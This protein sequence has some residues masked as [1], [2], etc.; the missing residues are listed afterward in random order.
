MNQALQDGYANASF[1]GFKS[2]HVF[3]QVQKEFEAD[4]AP[5]GILPWQRKVLPKANEIN[6]LGSHILHWIGLKELVGFRLPKF[7]K[8]TRVGFLWQD[9]L[10]KT[11]FARPPNYQPVAGGEPGVNKTKSES[12]SDNW[13]TPQHA[14][15]CLFCGCKGSCHSRR[16]GCSQ[17]FN[18]RS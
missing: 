10:C 13:P 16:C 8:L 6:A 18:A 15:T 2:Q 14:T 1:S 7:E 4:G 17:V 12:K 5:L 9:G 11:S 3:E